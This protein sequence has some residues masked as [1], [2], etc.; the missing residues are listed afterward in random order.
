MKLY[1][2]SILGIGIQLWKNKTKNEK[3]LLLY[4]LHSIEGRP[5]V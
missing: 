4:D 5:A 1:L 2:Y 3:L